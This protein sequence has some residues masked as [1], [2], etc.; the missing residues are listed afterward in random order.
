MT[1]A[2]ATSKAPKLIVVTNGKE[3][4]ARG[5]AAKTELAAE[6]AWEKSGSKGDRPETPNLDAIRAESANGGVKKRTGRKATGASTP[7]VEVLVTFHRSGK[8]VHERDQRIS[9]IAGRY[10]FG[11][12]PDGENHIGGGE[13]RTWLAG[14]G[15]KTPEASTWRVVLPNGE[16]I[17]ATLK[18]EKLPALS[19][20]DAK[21]VKTT[22]RSPAKK[23]TAKKATA[24]KAP[25]KTAAPRQAAAS[26]K[27]T[28]KKR[29]TAKRTTAR[30]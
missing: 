13:L 7:R 20:A 27:V 24:K 10:T 21:R 17:G 19:A 25:A 8:P 15:V 11:M 2:T 6:K 18:G 23:A 5:E 30:K 12:A 16:D 28:S 14:H 3:R 4:H 22:R 26:R 29:T 9:A 1:T